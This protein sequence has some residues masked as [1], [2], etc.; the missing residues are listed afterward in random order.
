MVKLSYALKLGNDEATS[1]P[2]ADS[3]F[4]VQVVKFF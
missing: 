3:R 4:W 2:D 1:A